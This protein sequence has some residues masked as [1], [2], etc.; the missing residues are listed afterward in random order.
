MDEA[1]LATLQLFATATAN[2]A[3][4][5]M[6][7]S[8][9]ALGMLRGAASDWGRD[10]SASVRRIATGAVA[11]CLAANL[12]GLWILTAVMSEQPMLA[13]L[14]SLG[15]VLMGSH[16]GH[17][18]AVGCVVLM[19]LFLYLLLERG[20]SRR[21][22]VVY[23]GAACA[24]IFAMSR[25][26]VSH[27]GATGTLLPVAADWLHLMSASTWAG[28]VMISAIDTLRRSK[29]EGLL[30]RTDCKSFVANVSAIAT[31]M[32]IGVVVTGAFSSWRA[33]GGSLT[34]LATS[35]YGL[36]LLVKLAGVGMATALGARNRFV[37]M[38]RLFAAVRSDGS[39]FPA[40]LRQF[41][42]VLGV[43]SVVLFGVLGL[44]A[45]LSTGSPP[46]AP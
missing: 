4:A 29:P 35:S 12:F 19:G 30:A 21:G 9:S 39:S 20:S 24:A 45:A 44:A 5:L 8:F 22:A 46:A 13:S 38:P 7:G 15:T 37:V 6:A 36:I 27:A 2:V 23:V 10:R 43:E 26:W 11:A 40:A 32:L 33:L 14:S 25:A 31:A 17:A 42:R 16:A 1:W 28:L 34:P 18:A 3:L 41:T